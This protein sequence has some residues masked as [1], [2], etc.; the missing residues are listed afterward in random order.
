M[1]LFRR[2]EK[3]QESAEKTAP[4]EEVSTPIPPKSTAVSAE[5]KAVKNVV[6]KPEVVGKGVLVGWFKKRIESGE[7]EEATR[8][9]DTLTLQFQ[10]G[11]IPFYIS[12]P[13]VGPIKLEEG[14]I[15]SYDALIIIP[16][17]LEEPL[18]SSDS[19][20][21]FLEKYKEH[22]KKPPHIRIQLLKNLE[23]LERKGIMR[24]KFVR[25]LLGV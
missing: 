24:S 15:V 6:V 23:E 13:S 1:W 25:R 5:P 21:S 7:L 20:S 3:E 16:A 17:E 14:R 19:L 2:K 4:R 8:Y 22:L 12:K 11:G 18:A 9:I 10:V